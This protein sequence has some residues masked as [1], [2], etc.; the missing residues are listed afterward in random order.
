MY[1]DFGP[2]PFRTYHSWFKRDGF[3]IM[4][5]QAWTSFSH[6]DSNSL[7]RFKKKLQDLKKIIRG[8]IKDKNISQ[9]GT[10]ISISDDLTN[11]DKELDRGV[12]SDELLTK[13]MEL[14]RKLHD[15][16]LMEV[17]DYAQKAK[18]KWAI[19]GDENSK[20][21]HG[22]INKKRSQL[23][24]RG[25]FVDGDWL[26]D[27]KHIKDAFKDHF[28]SRFKHP[29]RFRLKLKISFPNRLS[30]T[31]AI[32]MDNCITRSE[33]RKAVWECGENKSPGPDG[34]S[35]EFFRRYWNFIGPEFCS[36]V[37]SF[38]ISGFLPKGCNASFIALIPKV[39]DAK[40]VSDFRPISL[41][42]SVY[43]VIT[44][45]L[46]NRLAAVISDLVS[47]TQS[48]FV[49]NRHIL[50]G[51]FILNELL[52]WCKRKKKQ[53]LIFKVDFAK[54]YDSVRWDYLLDVL[55]AFGFG[56]NWCKWIRGIFSS[57]MASILVNGSPTSEFP[58]YCGLKQGDP[59]APFLFILVM[60]SLHISVSKAVNEGVFKGLSIQ[61][62]DPISHLFYADDAVFI[63]EWSEENLVNLVRILDCF[64]LASGLKINLH[65]SQVLG[66]GVPRDIVIQGA[67]LI[68]CDKI[69]ARL[70]KWKSKTLSVGGRLTLLKSVLGV[71]PLY[72]MSM[73][74][75]PKGVLLEMESIRSNFFKGGDQEDKKI[76][77]V[78][79]DKVL[80]S[81]K[82]GGLGV[83]SLFALNRGLLLK[84]VWRFLSQDGSIWSRVI[85]AIYGP[86]LDSHV[87]NFPSNWCS[88]L[89]EVQVLRAKG[90][91]FVSLC[92]KRV[93]NGCNTRFWLD[94][95]ILDMPFCVRFPR[96]YALETDKFASVAEKWEAPSFDSSFRR[97]AR[98]GAEREQ[99]LDMLS[100]LGTVTLSSS[101]DRWVCDINGEGEFRVKDIRS[102][103]DDLLLPSTDVATRWVKFIPIKIN[104]FAW[105]ARLDRLPTRCNL[106]KRGVILDSSLCPMCGLAPE[107]SYHVFFQC[108]MAKNILRRICRWW[109]LTW[110]DVSSFA[111]WYLWFDTIRLPPKLKLMLEGV[112]FVAWWH[113]WVFRNHTIFG[114]TAPR[115]SV[116][117]EDIVSRSFTWCGSR[118]N[119]SFSW[120]C[121]LKNPNL[122]SL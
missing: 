108:D 107:D 42:G 10:K 109:D 22:L 93:G 71:V 15:L 122:I 5:E 14:N 116:I 6:S 4:V 26:T 64:Y 21:F 94:T 53:A 78:A 68:G 12:V 48:A 51:P 95:W 41:I 97:H 74:K 72:A 58:F 92:K 40:F 85:S 46:A 52:A 35:F 59:L 3:D 33:I 98:D 88:I 120:E 9:A 67:S 96:I 7:I 13:R 36:A 110:C 44:K 84:W 20:F 17:K 49:A 100:M 113:I 37:E 38:F 75:A 57:A 56:P 91:D 80:S 87:A 8:W 119:R 25:I 45:I 11:I 101:I 83:S 121:W 23:S 106:I 73:Y 31:Q 43:K 114:V 63:G 60:E 29:D 117:H 24:I 39:L 16:K 70:S 2:S 61:G 1:T 79:W 19:E 112:F 66:V 104:V 50:D 118:C 28:A 18:V 32:D 69:Q 27:P 62:S 77:W 115:R 47:D 76:T 30:S 102:S 54:A 55:Q 99:W 86:F 90:F 105:R 81:K 65:K 34:F 103:L 89:R 111:D 82:K